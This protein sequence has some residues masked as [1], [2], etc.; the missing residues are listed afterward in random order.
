MT[1]CFI[2]RSSNFYYFRKTK[3]EHSIITSSPIFFCCVC[4]K[5]KAATLWVSVAAF[6]VDKLSFVLQVHVLRGKGGYANS[7]IKRSFSGGV[8]W[9]T[10]TGI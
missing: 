6:F 1:D 9:T 10:P 3:K 2:F 7:F 4:A 5:E 8:Y